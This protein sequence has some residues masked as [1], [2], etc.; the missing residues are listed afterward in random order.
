V[1][2]DTDSRLFDSHILELLKDA[3]KLF[4]S[5]YGQVNGQSIGRSQ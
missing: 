3:L 4:N 5:P 1:P 2:S